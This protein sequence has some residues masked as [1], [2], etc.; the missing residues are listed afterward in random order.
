VAEPTQFAARAA[1][2][3]TVMSKSLVAPPRERGRAT[4]VLLALL[5][6]AALI[7]AAEFY[8]LSTHRPGPPP[9][10]APSVAASAAP[11]AKTIPRGA[12]DTPRFEAT[13]GTKL[14]IAGWALDPAGIRAVEVRIGGRAQAASYGLARPDV[15]TAVPGDPAAAQSGFEFDADFA[16]AQPMRYEAA[17]VAI[18]LNG[19]EKLLARRSLIVPA[20]KSRWSA[21]LDARDRASA[22]PFHFLMMTSGVA[23]GGANE[24]DGEYVDYLSRTQRVGIAVPILYMR[25]TRGAAGDYAFDPDFDLARKCKARLVA[26]DNLNGVIRYALAHRLPTQFI[27]NGGIWADAS[28]ESREW[29]LTDHLEVDPSNCQW[30]NRNEVLPDDYMK[31]LA[32]S[33][34]SPELARSLTYHVYAKRVR[35]YKKRNLQAAAR[36]VAAFA[37]EHP[38]LFVGVALDADTY[39]NPFVRGGRRFDYNPGMLAQFRQWLTASGPYAGQPEPGVPDLSAHRRADPLTLAAINR[40]A[41]KAWKT[42]AEVDPPRAFPGDD[43]V[44]PAPGEIPYWEDPWYNEWD[45]FRKHIVQLH[46]AE[47]AKWTAEAGVPRERIFTAQ[48]FIAPDPGMK[49]VSIRVRDAGPDYD[50]A[51]VSIEGAAP[52]DGHLGTIL[53]GPAAANA[54]IFANG[55]SLFSNIARFDRAWAIVEY[56]A[57]DLKQ[58]T[59]LPAYEL[60]YRAFRDLFNYDGREIAVMA[61]NGSNGIF[62]G[63]PGYVPYTSWRNTPAESAMRDF[64]IS[65]ADVAPGSRLWTFGTSTHA[66]TDGWVASRGGVSAGNGYLAL[67]PQSGGRV[68]IVSPSDQVIRPTEHDFVA[69]DLPASAKLVRASVR[70]RDAAAG[71]QRIGE[72]TTSEITLAWPQGLRRHDAIIEQIALELTFADDAPKPLRGV[73]IHAN[74]RRSR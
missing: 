18:N 31:G 47:L 1:L 69:L 46:Y 26:E 41:R 9:V 49:P 38:D 27:L 14:H 54:T 63:E 43:R 4:G 72:G 3:C 28:C 30:D 33:T 35:A 34:D 71:W 16:D 44:P 20:A 24:V 60:S 22:R 25:T 45:A 51:G 64:M 70:A 37:R 40:L 23:N 53:Y 15:A 10:E 56:N 29:D 7:A 62:A 74:A 19:V 6:V 5:G 8:A 2:D 68:D 11:A 67:A 58:P 61:W 12:V 36:I 50:S 48:A 59:V 65:H 55:R 17:I 42:L 21:M 66:D 39:M 13:F 52:R 32:G 73:L 57:T